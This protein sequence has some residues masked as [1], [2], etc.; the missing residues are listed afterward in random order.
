MTNNFVKIPEVNLSSG[1]SIPIL[2][3][4]TFMIGG[5]HFSRDPNNDDDGQ[6]KN[7]RYA[8]DRGFRFIRT[9][10]NYAA[11]YC[12]VLI[13]RAIK[14]YDRE[15]LFIVSAANNKFAVDKDSLI[16]I[17]QGSLKS[18]DTD[19]FDIFIIGAINPDTST[20]S[21]LDGLIY[22]KQHDLAKEI[23]VANYR[24]PELQVAYEYLGKDLVYNE[25]HYNLIVREPE[26]FGA[27]DY[28]R[29]RNIILGAYRPLQF[30]QLSKPGIVI[31]DEMAKKYNKSQSQIALKWL[32][33]QKGVITMPKAIEQKHIDEDLQLFD[34]ELSS[35]DVT[36]LSH[37]FPIQMRLSDCS[38]PRKF[39]F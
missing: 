31:L 1:T 17:A 22:L 26:I 4:G 19:Y 24:L 7:I 12:E 14:N 20:K 18:L 3:L 21:I 5:D 27:L 6:I 30:G 39:K 10:H 38:E 28:C 25:M 37:D 15:K 16:K 9:A 33:Q 23:G 34:W 36:K 29:E 8:L 13:G 32:L 11:G 2:G 35:E